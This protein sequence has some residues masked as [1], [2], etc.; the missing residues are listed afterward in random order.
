MNPEPQWIPPTP[1]EISRWLRE[2]ALQ[3]A[4]RERFCRILSLQAPTFRSEYLRAELEHVGQPSVFRRDLGKIWGHLAKAA[5]GIAAMEPAEQMLFVREVVVRSPPGLPAPPARPVSLDNLHAY[6]ADCAASIAGLLSV[7][8]Q[9][10]S[11]DLSDSD[12]QGT[13]SC[14]CEEIRQCIDRDIIK[15]WRYLSQEC[16]DLDPPRSR[17]SWFVYAAGRYLDVLFPGRG[18]GVD[19][20]VTDALSEKDSGTL[21]VGALRWL[22][23]LV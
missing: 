15:V 22:Q 4:S 18:I 9:P 16:L 2:A 8:Q 23:D 21:G 17:E 14:R 11:F 6:L 3:P 5:D 12:L 13:E 1:D 7:F 19:H 10:P 20:K